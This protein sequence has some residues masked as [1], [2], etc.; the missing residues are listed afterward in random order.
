MFG[1]SESKKLRDLKPKDVH[2]A[3]KDGRII[4]ID[5]REPAEFASERIAGAIHRPL[6]SFDPTTLP[7]LNGAALVMQC[8]SG[9]RSAKAVAQCQKAGL[10]VDS[11]LAGGIAAWKAAGLPTVC[12]PVAHGR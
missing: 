1:F 10:E 12:G 6:S 3:M 9:V 7:P 8:G 5:V 2:Q 4:L 11:H